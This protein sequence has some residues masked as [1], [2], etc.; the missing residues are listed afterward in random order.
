MSQRE[1]DEALFATFGRDLVA[2]AEASVGPWVVRAVTERSG[3]ALSD[4]VAARAN[5]AATAA[6]VAVVA[7]LT[8][9]IETDIDQQRTTPLGVIRQA[10]Q[11]ATAVLDREGAPAVARDPD[12]VRLQPDDR[13]DLTIGSFSELSDELQEAGIKWGAG[14]AHLH[15]ARRRAEER[16]RG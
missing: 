12:A 14:K 15:L 9:L 2:A 5:E 11:F 6:T 1:A 3:G 13:Y 16:A 10:A 7:G 4:E 8:E